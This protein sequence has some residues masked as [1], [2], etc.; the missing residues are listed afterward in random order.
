MRSATESVIRAEELECQEDDMNVTD[1]TDQMKPDFPAL[2]AVDAMVS[3]FLKQACYYFQEQLK[4]ILKVNSTTSYT[5]VG[6]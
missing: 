6:K 5:R 3:F 4:N 2:S 1:D